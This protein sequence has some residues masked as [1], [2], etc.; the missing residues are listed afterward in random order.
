MMTI[1]RA[2]RGMLR[3]QPDIAINETAEVGGTTIVDLS[4]AN[5]RYVLRGLTL[6]SDDPGLGN[7]ITIGLVK[8][9]GD[10]EVEVDNFVIDQDND[11]EYQELTDMFGE[12]PIYGDIIKVTATSSA[13]SIG[14]TGQYSYAMG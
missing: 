3:E 9:V 4:S 6:K 12:G 11:H 2:S 8:L 5:K 7:T 13:G 1:E 10:I 14:I